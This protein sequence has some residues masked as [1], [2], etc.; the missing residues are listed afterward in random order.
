MPV[1]FAYLIVIVLLTLGAY[2]SIREKKLTLGGAIAAFCVGLTVF[3]GDGFRGLIMLTIFFLLGTLA[4]SWEKEKKD[5][6]K[7]KSD[8][9]TARNSGQVL[10]NGGIPAILGLMVVWFPH[11]AG[12]F[13]LMMAG[14]LSSA[15]ADTLSSE[16]G[17]LYGRWFFNIITFRKARKGL[18]GVI[19]ISGLLIGIAGSA[20]IALIYCLGSFGSKGF[21]LIILAG[22]IGN[23]ADSVLGALY[24]RKGIIGNNMVNFLN[25]LVAA[26]SVWFCSLLISL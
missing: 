3:A 8:R 1:S 11:Q 16:L 10:A 19:S 23:L 21:G 13:R 2:F 4:T 6:F 24:E 22:T 7:S 12:Y 9:A 17:M 18:D 14:A 25:T 26:L 5:Q 15:T 20:V